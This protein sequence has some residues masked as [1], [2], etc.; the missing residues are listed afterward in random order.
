MP[1]GKSELRSLHYIIRKLNPVEQDLN[2]KSKISKLLEQYRGDYLY[3][4]KEDKT[5]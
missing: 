1:M 3:D 2:T 4:T 5:S